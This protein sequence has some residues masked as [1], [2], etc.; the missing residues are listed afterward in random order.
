MTANELIAPQSRCFN[1]ILINSLSINQILEASIIF[2]VISQPCRHSCRD[3]RYVANALL[4]AFVDL[5]MAQ[6]AAET[7]ELIF[8][9]GLQDTVTYNILISHH[10]QVS[11]HC[12]S[13]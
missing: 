13:S 5:G 6:H 11:T 9:F 4:Q 8:S 2:Q 3:K 12:N 1:A 7:T 10:A